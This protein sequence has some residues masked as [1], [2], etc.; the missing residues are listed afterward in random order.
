MS[1]G[2]I[3]TDIQG[4]TLD[5]SDRELLLH[6]SV[7]GIILFTRNY[8]SVEQ[9]TALVKQ[10]HALREP[11]LLVAV[12]HEGGRVQRFQQGFTRL[13]AAQLIGQRYVQDR[14]HGL[15]FAEQ[16]GWLMAVELRATN[17]DFSF[18]PV[19]DVCDGVSQVIGDRS[20]HPQPQAVAKL[21]IAYMRGMRS[22]GMAAVGKHFPG[23]GSVK[24]DSHLSTPIDARDL[25]EIKQHSMY[26]FARLVA[27]GIEA[28][29]PAH[30]IYTKVDDK[31]AGFSAI[32]LGDILRQQIGFQGVIISDDISMVGAESAGD[33]VDRASLA[34]EAGC[35]MVLICNNRSAT[36][37]VVE[38][39]TIEMDARAQSRLMCMYG[40]YTSD[41]NSLI[42][43]PLWATTKDKISAILS[44]QI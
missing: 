27:A 8:V 24:E 10:I 43:D 16:V 15:V 37:K 40:K 23:H 33:F 28:I 32:W 12:D 44:E 14:R 31:P 11:R 5:S 36:I 17:I 29:M 13:P 26:P 20:F 7:G 21:A 34:L 38:N 41:R 9:I 4:T 6:P 39:L 18:A 1:L 2:P 42:H 30:V 22:A 19:L 3:M 35:D 25:A